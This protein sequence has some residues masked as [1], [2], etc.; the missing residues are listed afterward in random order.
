MSFL[1]FLSECHAE[2]QA[3]ELERGPCSGSS[4]L[5]PS[6]DEE[7]GLYVDS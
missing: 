5:L 7:D 3:G 4:S 2:I 6:T 1:V